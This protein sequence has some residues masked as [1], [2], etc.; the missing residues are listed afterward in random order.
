MLATQF[1]LKRSIL[2]NP[3]MLGFS[4][5]LCGAAFFWTGTARAQDASTYSPTPQTTAPADTIST[6]A[7]PDRVLLGSGIATLAMAYVPSAIVAAE[8]SLNT[9][10]VLYAPVVGPWVDLGNRPVCR[11]RVSCDLEKVNRVLIASDGV[12]QGIG[13]VALALSFVVPE[14]AKKVVVVQ[15][16]GVHVTPAQFG[17]HGYGV[18]A[19]GDF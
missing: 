6:Y 3:K 11:L 9:D 5:V 18:A 12:F 7:G 13:A 10:H 4:A 1:V 2:S 16:Q 8:S 15:T 19:I 17:S 14:R